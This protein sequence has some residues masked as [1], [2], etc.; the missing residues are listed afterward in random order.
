[1]SDVRVYDGVEVHTGTCRNCGLDI[2]R[3]V[4]MYRDGTK[5]KGGY[6]KHVNPHSSNR[7][8]CGFYASGELTLDHIYWIDGLDELIEED[9]DE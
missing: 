5:G 9:N 3:N 2:T 1:M 8:S 4:G 6:P 7:A